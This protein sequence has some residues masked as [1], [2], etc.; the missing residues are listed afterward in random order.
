MHVHL[1]QWLV[2]DHVICASAENSHVTGWTEQDQL[3]R[4]TLLRGDL[5]RLHTCSHACVHFS[6]A[7]IVIHADTR[8]HVLDSTRGDA[9]IGA[10][11]FDS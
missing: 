2:R 7:R 5:N 1:N 10:L 11:Q 6:L 9:L 4:V 8:R 3:L